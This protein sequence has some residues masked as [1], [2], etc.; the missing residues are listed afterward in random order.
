MTVELVRGQN[1]PL[2]GPRLEIRISVGKPVIA[3]ATLND[4]QGRLRE[5]GWIAHPAEPQLPGLEVSRQAAADHRLA[6]DLDALPGR[7]TG[8]TCFSRCP[9]GWGVR[10][11]SVVSTPP[12]WPSPSWTAE[13][14]RTTRSAVST[15]SRRS[16][17]WSCTAGREAGRS[18]PSDRGTRT[19]WRR[20][21][22][23]NSSRAPR[24]W[25]PRSMRRSPRAWPVRWRRLHRVRTRTAHGAERPWE[26]PRASRAPRRTA[27]AQRAAPVRVRAVTA[28]G[29][30]SA[31]GPGSGAGAGP[32]PTVPDQPA[33][34]DGRISYQHPSRA[35]AAPSSSQSGGQA[36]NEG[37]HVPVAGDANGWSMNERLYNQIWDMFEDLARTVA[38]Y[39]SAVDFAESRM[40]Q[41]LDKVLSDPRTRV[42]PA[43]DAARER[44]TCQARP[45]RRP[46][47]HR[48]RPR[49]RPAQGGGRRRR[50]R[51]APGLRPLGQPRLACL[52]GADGDADGAAAG[53]SQPPRE[54]G[55]A[56]PDARTAAAGAG[57][58]DRQRPR[59]LRASPRS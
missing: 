58:V 47:T 44:G 11:V 1:H 50:A 32:Q 13:R 42:G 46:G 25:P 56:H 37:A 36:G 20:C 27:A 28:P 6:V 51:A 35:Q 49:P 45:T 4:E 52:R 26:A 9:R 38:A 16:S 19:G 8:S 34:N 7:C 24:S 39:R 21:S 12:S 53:R 17:P 48:A 55:P 15:R 59:R 31:S 54:H 41:E 10:R 3:G 30:Q 40:E 18:A 22:P 43:A 23:T 57:P 33:S 29:Q 5:A 14:S 2:P